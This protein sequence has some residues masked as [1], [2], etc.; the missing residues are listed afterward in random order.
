MVMVDAALLTMPVPPL[1][2]PSVPASTMAPVVTP[3]GVRPVVPALNV[4]TPP[5]GAAHVASPRQNVEADADVPLLRLPTGRLPVTPVER[6]R[7]VPLTRP[8]AAGVPVA[9]VKTSAE[10]VPR[11]GV[12]RVGLFDRTTKTVPVEDVT[13][14]PPL[15]TGRVPVTPVAR[16]TLVIVLDAPLIDLLIKVWVAFVP[17]R[18]VL[19]EGNWVAGREIKTFLAP[20]LKLTAD[21]VEELKTVVLSRVEGDVN[22]PRPVSHSEVLGFSIT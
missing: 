3:D 18:V 1:A 10:G 2:V 7:P 17:T 6:G 9:F 12:T 21:P 4:V 19:A 15:A 20:A 11:S 14:V 5:A 22:V 16:D 8:I 13:P